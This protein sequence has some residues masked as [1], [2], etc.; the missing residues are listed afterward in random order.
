MQ[1]EQAWLNVVRFQVSMSS[2][3]QC[4]LLQDVMIDLYKR[5]IWKD[6]KTVNVVVTACFSKVTKVKFFFSSVWYVKQINR[7]RRS[8]DSAN[9]TEMMKEEIKVNQMIQNVI[10]RLTLV[11]VRSLLSSRSCAARDGLHSLLPSLFRFLLLPWSFSWAK[12]LLKRIRV[13]AKTMQV[14]H[15]IQF[16]CCCVYWLV[17][18]NLGMV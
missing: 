18:S 15:L 6:A 5:N 12:I 9:E 17:C 14:D 1:G 11:R 4:L 2:L 7:E 13:T 16:C 8:R 10:T 3:L